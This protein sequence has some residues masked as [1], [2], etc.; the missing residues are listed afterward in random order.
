M[1]HQLGNNPFGSIA[2]Q[3]NV[4]LQYFVGRKHTRSGVLA[5]K[6]GG[7][8]EVALKRFDMAQLFGKVGTSGPNAAHHCSGLQHKSF[9][10]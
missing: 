8:K 7:Q 10:F 1:T 6:G 2:S 9:E 4:S 5:E 3:L